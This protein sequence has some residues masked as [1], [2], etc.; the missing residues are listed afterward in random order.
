MAPK[1]L[2][3]L[4]MKSIAE[5]AMDLALERAGLS[6]IGMFLMMHPKAIE[7]EGAGVFEYAIHENGS[8]VPSVKARAKVD[9]FSGHVHAEASATG[10]SP[11][12]PAS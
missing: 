2:H 7:A 6:K 5:P 4:R 1:R 11:W 9:M 12:L 10:W 3:I 8:E